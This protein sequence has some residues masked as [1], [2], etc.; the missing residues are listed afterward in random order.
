MCKRSL[1]RPLTVLLQLIIT[2]TT[3][4]L[5]PT[6]ALIESRKR[7]R[8]LRESRSDCFQDASYVDPYYHQNCYSWTVQSV[9]D[10]FGPLFE[11]HNIAAEA[12]KSTLAQQYE[13]IAAKCPIAFGSLSSE[14]YVQPAQG[15]TK[16]DQYGSLQYPYEDVAYAVE[17]SIPRD[18]SGSPDMQRQHPFDTLLLLPG[19]Y[20]PTTDPM[21]YI[22]RQSS[23]TSISSTGGPAVTILDCLHQS[24]GLIMQLPIA[25]SGLTIQNCVALMNSVLP[26][27]L[28]VHAS[29]QT[30]VSFDIVYQ[31]NGGAVSTS[32][33]LYMTHC[34]VLN[35]TAISHGGSIF[36]TSE[37][38]G[39]VTN[40]ELVDTHILSSS[41]GCGGGAVAV[42]V[43]VAQNT[44]GSQLLS[45][46]DSTFKNNTA[47]VGGAIFTIWVSKAFAVLIDNSHFG[48]NQA[49][50]GGAI[51]GL[52]IQFK[53]SGVVFEGNVAKEPQIGSTSACLP[54][55]EVNIFLQY[56][57]TGG[58][59]SQLFSSLQ[60]HSTRFMNCYADK[61][62][63]VAILYTSGPEADTL[64]HLSQC[65]F[66]KNKAQHEGT[67]WTL[68]TTYANVLR[69]QDVLFVDNEAMRGAGM[70]FTG[71]GIV[72]IE[73]TLMVQNQA[74]IDGGGV[75]ISEHFQVRMLGTRAS[76][77]SAGRNGGA[78]SC[79][80]SSKLAINRS[81]FSNNSVEPSGKGGALAFNSL[82]AGSL[83][84]VGLAH[85]TAGVGGALYVSPE[86]GALALSGLKVWGNH[87]QHLGGGLCLL[88]QA[89]GVE[90]AN[91]S[92]LMNTVEQGGGGAA[93]LRSFTECLNCTLVANNTAE[94]AH[95]FMTV[96]TRLVLL[97]AAASNE[98]VLLHGESGEPL[99][100]ME[101]VIV[102][103]Y[104]NFIPLTEYS[105]KYAVMMTSN[106][107]EMSGHSKRIRH[108]RVIFDELI[109]SAPPGSVVQLTCE[110][111][112]QYSP[113][114]S[115]TVLW[116][117]ESNEAFG[118]K[119][120]LWQVDVIGVNFTV[121]LRECA[122]GAEGLSQDELRCDVCH[123]HNGYSVSSTQPCVL[124]GEDQKVE[125]QACIPV[126]VTSELPI[127]LLMAMIVGP[128]IGTACL[129]LA[130]FK[131]R[132]KILNR[133]VKERQQ[134]EAYSFQDKQN[135]LI[136]GH[137]MFV[138]H[139]LK[140]R[141]SSVWMALGTII[142][143]YNDSSSANSDINSSLPESDS[144]SA[145]DAGISQLLIQCSNELLEGLKMCDE[146][147][148]FTK[149]MTGTYVSDIH[150]SSI[151]ELF[152]KSFAGEGTQIRIDPAVPPL[153]LLDEYLFTI[154]LEIAF[155]SVSRQAGMTSPV[156]SCSVIDSAADFLVLETVFLSMG[157]A[158]ND[159]QKDFELGRGAPLM[160]LSKMEQ[161]FCDMLSDLLHG[162]FEAN[163]ISGS[164]AN[165][166]F[167]ARCGFAFATVEQRFIAPAGLVHPWWHDQSPE[168]LTTNALMD[169]PEVKVEDLELQ[170]NEKVPSA[171][172]IDPFSTQTAS[173]RK[174]REVVFDTMPRMNSLRNEMMMP[175]MNSMILDAQFTNDLSKDTSTLSDTPEVK[176]EDLELQ[177]N[178]KVPSALSFDPFSTQT[179]SCRKERDVVCDMVALRH[180]M[181]MMP[182]MNSMNLDAQF[183]NGLSQDTS[184][185]SDACS[186]ESSL[187]D[188]VSMGIE[189]ALPAGLRYAVC[190][191]NFLTLR[192]MKYFIRKT[193]QG[194]TRTK[195]RDP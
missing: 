12:E 189:T 86:G 60:L 11:P 44:S 9:D 36:V 195:E 140:N 157:G 118:K 54:A 64:S 125:G 85:N 82:C 104:G 66:E 137:Q 8:G 53:V 170:L 62:A 127:E 174:E 68:E 172:S 96:H 149:L 191:D 192:A 23:L 144:I 153:V 156:I 169:T 13:E 173:C 59:V 26:A 61:G 166:K 80:S 126:A 56:P 42:I 167:T 123:D 165:F 139:H 124:C 89:D 27:P 30:Y 116:A 52:G 141:I 31:I 120:Q 101:M 88:Q 112:E 162:G 49:A 160:L 105:S 168:L 134:E 29:P 98:S 194:E 181:M 185:L 121:L 10:I 182:R 150:P 178:E 131:I 71:R 63:G 177:L 39:T 110:G 114:S 18:S 21:I 183:T 81:A 130:L 111:T 14:R 188:A 136:R 187:T 1:R 158:E 129:S 76:L 35:C 184:T 117:D 164:W 128:F 79:S 22:P 24:Q 119:V 51:A 107:S 113:E 143:Y 25:L 43:T 3:R 94:Y 151:R 171:L 122:E 72:T 155:N 152:T 6:T 28:Q 99:P 38:S 32:S 19:T 115:G 133:K 186:D 180:E 33:D 148:G 92:F 142:P 190:D 95:D 175:R 83:V 108:G 41:A 163:Y 37:I 20:L 176:V 40:T 2:V 55:T 90:L 159:H 161:R 47:Q 77:N 103:S 102:D 135:L 78:L 87:A 75:L 97:G 16:E 73:D 70:S 65:V 193:L 5:P 179:A 57:L 69:L 109:V 67:L 34:T 91:I 48:Y 7:G 138:D 84:D 145:D 45:I 154:L 106:A 147:Q 100:P 46:R 74:V 15:R 4:D 17:L 132:V 146:Q 58:A 93:A 50:V